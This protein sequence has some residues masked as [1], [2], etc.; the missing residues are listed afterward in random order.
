MAGLGDS[1]KLSMEVVMEA[2]ILNGGPVVPLNTPERK[3]V[4]GTSEEEGTLT[5][6]E[7]ASLVRFVFMFK[8]VAL[9][10]V[11]FTLDV[12]PK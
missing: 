3:T 9:L 7:V 6:F 8:F 2:E 11:S 12:E 10:M 4:S 5:G 1:V